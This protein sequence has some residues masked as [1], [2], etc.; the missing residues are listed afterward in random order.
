MK[1][2]GILTILSFLFFGNSKLIELNENNF[3]T[4][5]GTVDSNSVSRWIREINLVNSNDIY[6]YI[7]S[8]GGSVT[9]G[10]TFIEQINSL[11][12][13]GKN[14]HCIADF[15]ASMAFIIFQSCPERYILSSSILMQHQ[16]SLELKGNLEN[17]QNYLVFIEEINSIVIKNQ[18]ERINMTSLAFQNKVMN[19]WWISG[20]FA[21]KNN[22]A[23][24]IVNVKCEKNLFNQIDEIDI[25]TIFGK[26]VLEFYSCPIINNPIKI[27][28]KINANQKINYY[29]HIKYFIPD[30]AI[31]ELRK[32][33]YVSSNI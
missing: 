3:V 24:E 17:L 11:Q 21:L 31:N 14:I 2:L 10:L 13:S 22:L 20:N 15:A 32:K 33:N 30:F 18:A 12:E 19:D 25:H 28:S 9:Q 29:D 1:F 7:K 6:L 8:P 5:R 16:M 4:L 26:I 27:N 23:D